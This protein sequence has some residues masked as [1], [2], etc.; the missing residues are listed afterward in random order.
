M[1]V[2]GQ[3]RVAPLQPVRKNKTPKGRTIMK[4]LSVKQTAE[5]WKVSPAMVRRYC[6]QGRI[7][8]AVMEEVGWKVPEKAKKPVS[9]NEPPVKEPEISP[10][11]KKLIAQ[12][13]K[14]HYHG[15]YDYVQIYLT[16]C[17]CRMASG[18]LTQKQVEQSRHFPAVNIF[19]RYPA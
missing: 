5:K 7:K 15:L 6:L 10:L 13:K 11:A 3:G 1:K 4:Y 9:T 17:S 8:G 18:R 14:K 16:Y 12:K 2:A 19:D